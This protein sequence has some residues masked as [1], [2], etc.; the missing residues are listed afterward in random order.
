MA[1]LSSNVVILFATAA[2]FAFFFPLWKDAEY[3][4]LSFQPLT[5]ALIPIGLV[6]LPFAALFGLGAALGMT[7]NVTL[8]CFLGAGLLTFLVNRIGLSGLLR[9]VLLLAASVGMTYCLPADG[10]QAPVA[11]AILGLLT[12]KIAD[13]ILFAEK[14]IYDD[15][16]APL[17]WLA[18]VLWIYSSGQP[19]AYATRDAGILLGTIAVCLIL[20]IMQRPFMTDD[21][22]LV[23]RVVLA[24]TGGLGTLLVINKLM[25]AVSMSSIALLVGG[26]L[27]ATYLFQNVDLDGEEKIGPTAGI[28]MLIIIGV[29]TLVATR[30]WGMFGLV[31]MIPTAILPFRGGFAQYAGL[32]FISRV[33]LQSFVASYNSN[34]TGINVTHAYTGAAL[35]AGFIAIAVLFLLM[36]EV[37]DR[38][39]RAAL[40]LA[41]GALLPIGASYYLH[42]EPTSS[43][44]V[45]ATV[46]GVIFACI[47][48]ALQKGLTAPIL[49]FGNLLLVPSMMAA[50]GIVYGALIEL[51]VAASNEQRLM[52]LGG[53][54][55]LAI[56]C[57]L[58][59]WFTSRKNGAK[60]AVATK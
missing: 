52:I 17:S 8:P 54:A 15:V 46:A 33:L 22:W 7:V 56:I 41:A 16:V 4:R 57:L 10:A 32:F 30:F 29:L 24:A 51:G 1:N 45:S 34:V 12:A 38:R 53:V 36:R 39:G 9:G 50:A 59:S 60:T 21:R 26:A 20:R 58:F 42:A 23:K 55:A 3:K 43:L 27:F 18:G 2:A 5:A 19:S 28:Q 31:M 49:G 44:L 35:Y 25:L 37:A 47:G 48:P 14:P 11:A 13:N 6:L 40:F